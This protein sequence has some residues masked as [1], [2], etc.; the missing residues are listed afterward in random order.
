MVSKKEKEVSKTNSEEQLDKELKTEDNIITRH[1]NKE[2]RQFN[3]GT[4]LL[5]LEN[6]IKTMQVAIQDRDLIIGK[7]EASI[8][9][10]EDGMAFFAND[11]EQRYGKSIIIPSNSEINAFKK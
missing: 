10:L 1:T 3:F 9:A 8:R 4:A 2:T 6:L 5:E 11:W 7:Q